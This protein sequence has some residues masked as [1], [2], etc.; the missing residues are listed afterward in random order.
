MQRVLGMGKIFRAQHWR[1][2][3]GSR[4][5]FSTIGTIPDFLTSWP[6]DLSSFQASFLR[7]KGAMQRRI[8]EG[9]ASTSKTQLI[10]RYP[11]ETKFISMANVRLA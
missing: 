6:P 2:R 3:H 4:R 7:S 11:D 5:V 10:T 1:K 9:N 8:Y